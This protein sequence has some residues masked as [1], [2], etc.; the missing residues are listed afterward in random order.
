MVAHAAG[1][2]GRHADD[3]DP[4]RRSSRGAVIH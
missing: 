2:A 4:P 1:R 3:R